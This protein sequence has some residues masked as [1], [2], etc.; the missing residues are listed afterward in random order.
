MLERL[1]ATE[2]AM[3]RHLSDRGAAGEMMARYGV[4]RC[5]AQRWCLEVRRR[6]QTEAGR[7]LTTARAEL[8]GE[9]RAR[10]AR[11]FCRA[12]AVHDYATALAAA[13]RMAQLDGFLC[14]PGCA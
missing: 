1:D 5:T 6:W 2:M 7:R 12:V 9:H 11:I 3:L 13:L 4:R 14:G 10:L 8:L